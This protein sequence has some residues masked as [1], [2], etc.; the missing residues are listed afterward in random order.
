[1]AGLE[2]ES[3]LSASSDL[4]C[5]LY[6]HRQQFSE[7]AEC[8]DL[9]LALAVIHEALICPGSGIAVSPSSWASQV[10]FGESPFHCISV[11][12]AWAEDGPAGMVPPA[13]SPVL[14]CGG[15]VLHELPC[16]SSSSAQPRSC[17]LPLP[18][19]LASW[20]QKPSK[21]ASAPH[22]DIESYT[23]FL[24]LLA[25]FYFIVS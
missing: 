3:T 25:W 5:P 13:P 11:L 16:R 18:V 8:R 15:L 17:F 4:H 2:L 20:T 7:W 23:G 6:L 19:L 9:I 12:W 14:P 21:K 1:M 10:H 22:T 24:V